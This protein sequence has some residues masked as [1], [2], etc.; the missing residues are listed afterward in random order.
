MASQIAVFVVIILLTARIG[1]AIG[2]N[3]QAI[4]TFGD[5][6]VDAGNNHFIKNCSAQADFQPYGS[7]YF[8]KPTG[9]FTNGR[10]VPDFLSQFLGIPI[11]KPFLQVQLEL[12]KGTKCGYPSNGVNFAS[13]GSGML[14][15][16]NKDWG[17]IPI[18]AQLKH[19]QALV[20]HNRFNK[21][22]IKQSLFLLESGS[23]DI[24]NYFNPFYSPTLDPDAYVQAMLTEATSLISQLYRLGARRITAVG[25]GPVGCIPARALLPGAPIKKCFGKMNKM[26]KDYNKGLEALVNAMPVNYPGI[27]GV[28]GDVYLTTQKLRAMPTT[29][30]FVN[31]THACCGDGVLGGTLQCGKEGYKMCSNPDQFLFWDYFHPTEHTYNFISKGLWA[32]GKASIRP[33]NLKTMAN[34]TLPIL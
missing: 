30:G 27:V 15:Q 22:L 25:L 20:K 3:V 16:T 10:T 28:Y 23:N 31:V 32:G 6:I 33:I 9:R 5:S 14:M 26:V 18:Q 12:A 17:V 29:Y 13:A 1:S 4:F 8:H 21:K 7:S 24:F 11:Q 2:C 34:L 19:F